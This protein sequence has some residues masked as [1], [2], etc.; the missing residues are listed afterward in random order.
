V[1]CPEATELAVLHDDLVPHPHGVAVDHAAHVREV[2]Q[3][4]H[5]GDHPVGVVGDAVALAAIDDA[6][7]PVRNL[8]AELSLHRDT[9]RLRSTELNTV[10]GRAHRPHPGGP[11][12]RRT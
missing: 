5:L 8:I 4:R 11:R 12:G 10:L 7:D 6:Q 2:N 1:D 3:L 9:L